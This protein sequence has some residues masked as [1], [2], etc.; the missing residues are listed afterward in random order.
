[1][2]VT[3]TASALE[4]IWEYLE[5]QPEIAT[6]AARIALND[7]G[8]DGLKLLRVAVEDEAAFPPGYVDK[9]RLG[10]SK[11]ARNDDLRI[12]ISARQRPTSL[13]RFAKNLKWPMKG[14][15][16]PDGQTVEV[17]RGRPIKMKGAFPVRLRAGASLTDNNFNVGLAIRLKPGETISNKRV[18]VQPGNQLQILYGPSVDQVA[19]EVMAEQAEHV[20][21][22]IELEFYRQFQRLNDKA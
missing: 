2:T 10:I 18:T 11:Y 22:A 12:V 19:G 6:E 4:G 5:R 20:V 13:A 1:M 17:H 8:E 9:D 7:G 21:D 14:Q 16:R 15:P 3:V